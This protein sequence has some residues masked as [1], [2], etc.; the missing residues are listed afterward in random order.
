MQNFCTLILCYVTNCIPMS[1]DQSTCIPCR[2]WK[3]RGCCQVVEGCLPHRV[4]FSFP[5]FTYRVRCHIHNRLVSLRSLQLQMFIQKPLV[6]FML[7]SGVLL[8]MSC[9]RYDIIK[10]MGGKLNTSVPSHQKRYHRNSVVCVH[11]LMI[12]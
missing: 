3:Y 11:Y 2:L 12:A 9:D 5:E 10:C 1:R 4:L 7:L 8:F 6:L